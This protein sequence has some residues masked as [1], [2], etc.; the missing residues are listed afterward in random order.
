MDDIDWGLHTFKRED[1]KML[2]EIGLEFFF[3]AYRDTTRNVKKW[4]K[5]LPRWWMESKAQAWRYA[6]AWWR[7]QTPP[8]FPD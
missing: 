4:S 6:M 7:L 8:E 5:P 1:Y 3:D 2:L